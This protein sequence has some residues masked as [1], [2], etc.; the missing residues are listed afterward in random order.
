MLKRKMT[1][2]LLMGLSTCAL[3][4]C[5]S[6][7]TL[8]FLNWG[9][10]IDETMLEAFEDKY[11]C[12]VLMDLGESNEIF[13]SK[14]RGGTTVYDVVCPSDYMVEKMYTNDMLEKID[15]SK[16]TNS[17]YSPDSDNVRLGVKSIMSDMDTNL[18]KN[19]GDKYNSGDIK[20]YFVPYL[21]GTW[22]IMYSTSK[23]GLEKAV[24][25]NANQWA[26]LFD[27]TATPTGT[28]VAM[29]DSHQHAYYAASRYFEKESP[30][31]VD[32]GVELSNSDLARIQSLIEDMNYDA[33]GTDTIKK[34]IVAGNIDLGFM[35]T[36]DFLYYYCENA[37]NVALEAYVA[38]DATY[39]NLNEV[40]NTL[41]DSSKRVFEGKNGSYE[42]GFD[43]FI[44]DDTIAFCDNLVI[45]KD[46]ANKDLAYKFI[47]FMSSYTTS[48]SLDDEGNE[49]DISKLEFGAEGMYTPCFTNTY[50]VSYDACTIDVY[51][52]LK[53]LQDYEFTKEDADLFEEEISSG[54]APDETTLY[55]ILYD[56]VVGISFDKYYPKDTTKGAILATFQRQYID[57][58]NA[59]F[60]NARA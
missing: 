29:Y 2:L 22:G 17:N 47:D 3:A 52:S 25:T 59:T 55:G 40:I 43:C 9:E 51:D 20:N 53:E 57:Q 19:L 41:T 16:L 32:Y 35:W 38:G 10:Y 28:R 60:N 5:Q 21:W 26:C 34:D 45:T 18:K 42:I 39:E 54:V 44:P 50:Y 15:F 1:S 33:W 49:P 27:R 14:V 24:T 30:L 12:N 37:A 7:E 13:Y 23:E 56:V 31:A 36:G 48:T 46:A 8:L 58:I 6:R 11:N 4:S